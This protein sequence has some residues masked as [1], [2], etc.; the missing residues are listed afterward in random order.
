MADH[1]AGSGDEPLVAVAGGGA[2]ATLVAAHLLR[3]AGPVPRL[4]L[5]DRWGC[6]GAARRTPP[7]TRTTC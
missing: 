4:L 7:T 6:T 2:S 3:R 5:I 1:V